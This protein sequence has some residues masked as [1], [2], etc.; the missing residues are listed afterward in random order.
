MVGEG[1][2]TGYYNKP[3]ENYSDHNVAFSFK[4]SPINIF[5][6]E[7]ETFFAK[8]KFGLGMEISA[9]YFILLKFHDDYSINSSSF[10]LR[11]GG[12]WSLL[13][14]GLYVPFAYYR[15]I[16]GKNVFFSYE[17]GLAYYET[18]NDIPPVF[19]YGNINVGFYFS[20]KVNRK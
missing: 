2:E 6:Y 10:G 5:S 18:N 19:L 4:F 9:G 15:E 17:A 7:L 1:D 3:K 12:G 13:L 14:D 8:S 11:L 20:R 16:R